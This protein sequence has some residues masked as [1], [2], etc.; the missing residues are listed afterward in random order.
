MHMGS[1]VMGYV[2]DF[3][4]KPEDESHETENDP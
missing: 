1:R 2:V 4:I 3:L